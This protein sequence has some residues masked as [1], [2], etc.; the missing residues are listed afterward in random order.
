MIKIFTYVIIFLFSFSFSYAQNANNTS[1][2]LLRK[3]TV[4]IYKAQKQMLANQ[5]TDANGKLAK[6]VLYQSYAVKLFNENKFNEANCASALSRK[7]A[8]EII[9]SIDKKTDDY[10]SLT[11]EERLNLKNCLKE[12]ELNQNAKKYFKDRSESDA[13]YL[14]PSKLS[15]YNIDL[16]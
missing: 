15:E 7:Y 14:D 11:S 16:N 6:A 9:Q 8:L 5:K 13:E 3:S 2:D 4:S 12:T 10:F 1:A